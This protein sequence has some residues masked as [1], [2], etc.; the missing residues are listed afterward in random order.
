MIYNRSRIYSQSHL[1]KPAC[2]PEASNAGRVALTLRACEG[3]SDLEKGLFVAAGYA[4]LAMRASQ[5]DRL[6]LILTTLI[7]LS[8]SSIHDPSYIFHDFLCGKIIL[9]RNPVKNLALSI[10]IAIRQFLLEFGIQCC[11]RV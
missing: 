11:I 1:I 6:F 7:Y 9:M 4:T 3:S 2:H 8:L 5:N 10:F